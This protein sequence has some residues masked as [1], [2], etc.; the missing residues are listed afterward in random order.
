M[1]LVLERC[2]IRRWRLDDAESLARHANNRKVWLAVRDLF[3]H[4][5][6][7][8]DAHEFLQRVI[9]QQPSMKFCIEIDGT[10]VRGIGVHPGQDVHRYTATV[11][12]WLGE[13]FW[14]RG[15]ITEAVTAVTDLCFE[16]FPL[17]RISAEVFSN[18]PASARVLE[19]A[20]FTFEGC[21]K[22]NVFKDGKL[23][24]SLLYARTK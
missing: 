14:G 11:G 13:V 12:Y 24:D 20:G 1:Q 16:N 17:R 7:I 5:Y 18:N 4:P 8:Q 23:L 10:A 19:K 6:T 2:T 21:L 22:N 15:I 3:P 9:S